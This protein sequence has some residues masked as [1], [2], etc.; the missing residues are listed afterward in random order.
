MK[1]STILISLAATFPLATTAFPPEETQSNYSDK[2]KE[3][4]SEQP[5]KFSQLISLSELK[6]NEQK[7]K[8]IVGLENIE[9]LKNI[10]SGIRVH[11]P[12]GSYDP[13]TMIREKKKLG[14]SIFTIKNKK[15]SECL[16][17]SYRFDF[18][19]NFEF[20]NGGK[21]P[22][23]YGGQTISGG[24]RANGYNGFTVRLTWDKDGKGSIYAYTPKNESTYGSRLGSEKWPLTRTESN[25]ITMYIQLNDINKSNGTLKVWHNNR[26][27][28]DIG[29][30]TFRNTESLK[31]DGVIFS[32]FFGGSN[33]SYATPVDTYIDFYDMKIS[34]YP[35]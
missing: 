15:I 27:V 32:T 26:K 29:D 10:Q 30:I 18:A 2:E 34:N 25:K 19:P 28:V 33:E 8:K 7:E 5:Y 23:L 6:T 14:G 31:I 4:A 1:T 16:Y 20:K 35:I 3:C 9:L 12:E 21:L 11:Y 17:L 22:G 24:K 13:G